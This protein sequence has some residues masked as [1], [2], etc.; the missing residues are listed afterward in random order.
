MKALFNR[1]M[2]YLKGVHSSGSA[3]S[4]KRHYGGLLITSYIIL[5]AFNY[6]GAD[7]MLYAGCALVAGGLAEKYFVNKK[8]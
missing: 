6:T 3:E 4:A 5:T 1:L 7:E 2:H 8:K